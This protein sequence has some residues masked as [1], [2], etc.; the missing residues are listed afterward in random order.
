M[1]TK[2][3]SIIVT[4]GALAALLLA[5]G[6]SASEPRLE[7][8]EPSEGNADYQIIKK[9]VV[10]QHET[11][12]VLD[13]ETMAFLE[14]NTFGHDPVNADFLQT[15]TADAIEAYTSPC[16]GEGFSDAVDARTGISGLIL[17]YCSLRADFLGVPAGDVAPSIPLHSDWPDGGLYDT[18][19][20][21]APQLMPYTSWPVGY[22][23]Y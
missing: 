22:T 2:R 1:K 12:V 11:D 3:F 18:P 15:D 19:A 16:Q 10:V 5:T 6:A 8:N 4:A 17:A 20:D 14:I 9:E 13:Y 21:V 23:D 7:P